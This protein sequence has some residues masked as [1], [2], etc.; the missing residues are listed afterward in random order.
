MPRQPAEPRGR[1]T[2]RLLVRHQSFL[3]LPSA[4]AR[5]RRLQLRRGR[6]SRPSASALSKVSPWTARSASRAARRKT[7]AQQDQVRQRQ[8]KPAATTVG[9]KQVEK[10]QRRPD[11]SAKGEPR[12]QP[13]PPVSTPPTNSGARSTEGFS[14]RARCSALPAIG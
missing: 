6:A 8:A 7:S 12:A 11:V 14:G 13:A 4:A 9:P 10:D 1:R 3:L 5:N 2:G